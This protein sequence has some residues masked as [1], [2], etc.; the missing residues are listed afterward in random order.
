MGYYTYFNGKFTL[1][2]EAPQDVV[3]CVNQIEDGFRTVKRKDVISSRVI[4]EVRHEG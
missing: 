3:D 2:A 4:P 1:G